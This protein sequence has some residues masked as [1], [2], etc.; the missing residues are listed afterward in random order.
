MHDRDAVDNREDAALA[1][2][3]AILNVIAI[4]PMEHRRDEVETAAAVRAPEDVEGGDVHQ[5]LRI[6]SILLQTRFTRVCTKGMA[7]D[8]LSPGSV[9]TSLAPSHGRWIFKK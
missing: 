7:A 9:Q 8:F 3:N 4:A 2:E 1:A 6:E 5:N